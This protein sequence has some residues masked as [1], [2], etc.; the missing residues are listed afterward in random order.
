MRPRSRSCC[1]RWSPR[2]C[3]SGRRS[4]LDLPWIAPD[5]TIY[6]LL[7]RSLWEDGWPSLL[8]TGAASYSFVYPALIGLP[9][10]F[11]DLATGVTAVQ[12]LGALLMSATAFVVYLWG[13]GP[14]G[15]WWAVAAAGLT[16]AVPDLAYSG[17][18]M[19]EVAVFP[20]AT[21]ALWAIASAI[22]RPS[23]ARQALA[24]GAIVLALAT[25]VR[26]VA[27]IPTLFVAVALQ[28]G[29][30]RSLEPARRLAVLLAGTAGACAV[31]AGR[32]RDRRPLARPLRR[33]CRRRRRLR[34]TG[35][36]EGR[37]LARRGCLRGR[38]GRS[39]DRARSDVD[40]MRCPAR[41]RS[42]RRCARR[43]HRCVDVVS[44]ARN[45]NLRLE[46]GSG[47]SHSGTC[48]RSC[49]R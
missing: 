27:L 8:G 3:A 17:L 38:R 9:L 34:A 33:V 23:L 44:R 14:L 21:L 2:A 22:A 7:G 20:I 46:A 19:S 41:A 31:T 42:C 45:R 47:T 40:R 24:G 16:L 4:G 25:H 6:A 29:F 48:S 18:V 28:C 11:G 49:R 43:D 32:L 13:R 15:A 10:A 26:L 30:V 37:G 36:G 12:A 35:G 5:E 39:P 1:S